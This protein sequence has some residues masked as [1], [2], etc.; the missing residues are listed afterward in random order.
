[1]AETTAGLALLMPYTALLDPTP[2]DTP[3]VDP[4]GRLMFAIT[5]V[6]SG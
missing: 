5:L 6:P 2:L 1:V 4:F 3:M